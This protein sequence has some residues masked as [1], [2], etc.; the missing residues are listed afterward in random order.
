MSQSNSFAYQWNLAEENKAIDTSL[1]KLDFLD[2]AEQENFEWKDELGMGEEDLCGLL[3]SLIFMSDRPMSIDKMKKHISD[4]L[5][6]RVIH[7]SLKTLQNQY[8]NSL[9]GIRLM[10]VAHGYQFRTKPKFAKFIHRFFKVDTLTLTPSTLEVLALIT[11][12]QPISKT[13]VDEIRGVDSAHLIRT[14]IDKRLV[15]M[16]GRSDEELGRPS[17][18]ETTEEFLDVFNLRSLEDLPTESE[19][20]ELATAK[21]VGEIE[22]IKKIVEGDKSRFVFDE[23]DELNE[24]GETIKNIDIETE[25]LKM[26]KAEAKKE[27]EP[28]GKKTA[29][30]L[31]EEFVGQKESKD[32]NLKAALSALVTTVSEFTIKSLRKSLRDEENK[33]I[34]TDKELMNELTSEIDKIKDVEENLMNKA[35][36]HDL[37]LNF[38]AED[39]DSVESN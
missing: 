14:L 8:E 17:L 22:D 23:M 32:Q 35:Q 27:A 21:S 9:H 37:D 2:P 34:E 33:D 6:L 39:Q 20:Y 18:Y 12:R 10:E 26:V 5:P 30:D 31:L 36:E 15:R 38:L 25:F 28:E 7:Q 29:F 19:L 13:K 1:M 16:S 4:K 24:L 11:Y 3:E